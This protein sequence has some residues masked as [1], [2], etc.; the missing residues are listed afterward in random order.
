MCNEGFEKSGEL[1]RGLK[2]AVR[3]GVSGNGKSER[4]NT[5]RG[6]GQ[7]SCNETLKVEEN[8]R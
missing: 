7:S 5:A 2:G 3:V 6:K 8:E 4:G 1:Q